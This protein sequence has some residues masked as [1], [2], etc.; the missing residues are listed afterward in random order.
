MNLWCGFMLAL[1]AG[2]RTASAA[3]QPKDAAA[4]PTP[5]YGAPRDAVREPAHVVATGTGTEA[6][7]HAAAAE[8]VYVGS[9]PGRF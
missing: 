2:T 6:G 9:A 5:P 7:T 4:H 3:R 8:P 1:V